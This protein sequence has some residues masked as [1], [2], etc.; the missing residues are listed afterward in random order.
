[1][2]L[3]NYFFAG[4]L[5]AI[6]CV[7]FDSPVQQKA[8]NLLSKENATKWRGYNA[9]TFAPGWKISNGVLSLDPNV[10]DKS[11][12]GGKDLIF[13]GQEFEYFELTAEWKID[14]GANSGIFYHLKEGDGY[15]TTMSPEYQVIDDVNF[16]AMNPGLKGYNEQFGVEHPEL[17]QDWQKAGAD[18]AMYAADESKKVLHPYGEWNTTKIVV[19]PGRTE[20]WL[21]GVKLISFE[22]WSDDWYARKK[23]GKFAKDEK[24]GTAKTGYIGFQHHGGQL[25]FRNVIVKPL[26]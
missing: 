1:M 4:L 11:Y 15:A 9:Q 26:K 2:R 7:G 10:T 18:Y 17:L 6:I 24:Y 13:G 14:K 5:F 21:N 22:P 12:K 19:A 25:S 8:I 16:A 20:H 3:F 23:A